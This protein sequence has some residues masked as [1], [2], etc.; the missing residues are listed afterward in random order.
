MN[1]FKVC[2]K[3]CVL[4]WVINFLKLFIIDMCKIVF[5]FSIVIMNYSILYKYKEVGLLNWLCVCLL[6]FYNV[7]EN[8]GIYELCVF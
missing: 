2:F 6:R 5:S 4:K 8:F 1:S 3:F 7:C